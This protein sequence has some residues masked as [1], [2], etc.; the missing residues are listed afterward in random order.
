MSHTFGLDWGNLKCPKWVTCF[1]PEMEGCNFERGQWVNSP[2]S[3]TFEFGSGNALTPATRFFSSRYSNS[4]LVMADG[5]EG[6][7]SDE[8]KRSLDG[9]EQPAVA[10]ISQTEAKNDPNGRSGYGNELSGSALLRQLKRHYVLHSIYYDSCSASKRFVCANIQFDKCYIAL[11]PQNKPH[12]IN[13]IP[14]N[15]RLDN[16]IFDL[17]LDIINFSRSY[18]RMIICEIETVSFL[19]ILRL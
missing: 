13:R 2:Q 15:M 18:K 12:R 16:L 3:K 8:L 19:F 17:L 7:S 14:Q 9:K 1:D 5:W 4:G 10:G 6:G 11:K